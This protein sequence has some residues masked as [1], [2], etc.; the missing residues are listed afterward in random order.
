[1]MIWKFIPIILYITVGYLVV[2]GGKYLFN[3]IK[4][5]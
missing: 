4:K 2:K 3:K 1:M 5:L